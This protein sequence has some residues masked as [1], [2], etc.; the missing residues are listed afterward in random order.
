MEHR[1]STVL[2]SSGSLRRR[3]PGQAWLGDVRF[4]Y[5]TNGARLQSAAPFG[6][7]LYAAGLDRGDVLQSIDGDPIT[8]SERFDLALG[9]HAPGD[10][11]QVVF[12]RRGASNAS[13]A[14]LVLAEDPH[15]EIAVGS[16]ADGAARAFRASWLESRI[17]N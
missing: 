5:G 3:A 4:E 16:D 8:S 7:P 11:V 12:L 17:R 13:S 2:T 6:S 14:T 9:D 10:A 15:V 1:N